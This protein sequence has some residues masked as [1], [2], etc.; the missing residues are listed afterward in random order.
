[1][2]DILSTVVKARHFDTLRVPKRYPQIVATDKKTRLFDAAECAG[3][4]TLA[5][6]QVD[7]VL[8]NAYTAAF[9]TLLNV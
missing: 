3:S 6:G 2:T 4:A 5:R 7:K 9:V 8:A 1:M